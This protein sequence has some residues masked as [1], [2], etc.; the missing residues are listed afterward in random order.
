[1][2]ACDLQKQ[3]A[4]L[5]L[6]EMAENHSKAEVSNVTDEKCAKKTPRLPR[7]TP[8][9]P[10]PRK[11]LPPREV[12]QIGSVQE[13]Q[14]SSYL[15]RK[16]EHVSEQGNKHEAQLAPRPQPKPR[17]KLNSVSSPQNIAKLPSNLL[18]EHLPHS[19]S[20]SGYP[21]AYQPQG[22]TVCVHRPLIQPP[23][24]REEIGGIVCM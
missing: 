12:Q 16:E 6:L 18:Q 14:L 20:F 13:E 2:H 22:E 15:K 7:T 24:N 23:L 19:K 4:D 5:V 3:R 21:M 1:M 8:P 11:K 17:R 9:K 10:V